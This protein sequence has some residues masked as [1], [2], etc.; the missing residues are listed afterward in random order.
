MLKFRWQNHNEFESKMAWHDYFALM[1]NE[2]SV[3]LV[4]KY[5]WMDEPDK[6]SSTFVIQILGWTIYQ[7]IWKCFPDEEK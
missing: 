7:R 3:L 4:R 1:F 5:D 2:F 6:E